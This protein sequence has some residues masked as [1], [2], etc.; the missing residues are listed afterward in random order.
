MATRCR[1]GNRANRLFQWL[2]RD[3]RG[4]SR[5]LNAGTE[6][7][8]QVLPNDKAKLFLRHGRA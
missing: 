6:A 2:L 4:T 3:L 8:L 5:F 1:Q 7:F